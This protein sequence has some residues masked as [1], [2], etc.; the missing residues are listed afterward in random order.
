MMIK[1]VIT[2]L[3][4]LFLFFNPAMADMG[5]TQLP[6]GSTIIIK[7]DG[8]FKIKSVPGLGK[9]QYEVNGNDRK[10]K[11]IT[12][13]FINAKETKE[14][15][16]LIIKHKPGTRAYDR[17]PE[18]NL[19]VDSKFNILFSKV[20]GYYVIE[21]LA[22]A[23]T[24]KIKGGRLVIK[25]CQGKIDLEA[26]DGNIKIIEHRSKQEPFSLE[27]KQGIISVEL[28]NQKTICPGEIILKS[29]RV[30][31]KM[32]KPAALDFIG[33]VKEGVVI[34]NLPIS[35]KE[36]GVI[37]F[38]SMGGGTTWQVNIEKGILNLDLPSY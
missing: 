5:E 37:A 20:K 12:G 15:Y 18:V 11:P 23:I 33:E 9:I 32:T 10:G 7:I 30:S 29:G 22:G 13:L 25:E 38:R 2:S 26:K 8:K 31:W 21:N 27:M 35:R 16:L 34:C 36:Q 28:G 6:Q 24:G 4:S 19:N 14:G 3:F 1:T 17:L